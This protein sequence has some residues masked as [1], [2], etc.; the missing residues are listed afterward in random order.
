[1]AEIYGD[2]EGLH[3]DDFHTDR[4]ISVTQTQGHV[5]NDTFIPEA[6]DAPISLARIS[7]SLFSFLINLIF[8]RKISR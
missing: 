4:K 8:P 1:M 7:P 2:T 6:R 5:P 3:E